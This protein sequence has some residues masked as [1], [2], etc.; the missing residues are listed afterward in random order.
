MSVPF[1]LVLIGTCEKIK[2][3]CIAHSAKIHLFPLKSTTSIWIDGGELETYRKKHP[4]V[5]KSPEKETSQYLD[6]LGVRVKKI[7]KI[8]AWPH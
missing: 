6:L 5:K 4:E 8:V 3:L 2:F 7:A 1:P